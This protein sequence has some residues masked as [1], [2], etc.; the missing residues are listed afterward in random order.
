M[1]LLVDEDVAGSH[2]SDIP[3]VSLEIPLGCDESVEE[4]PEVCLFEIFLFRSPP[5]DFIPKV[6]GK[7]RVC[8]ESSSSGAAHFL[9]RGEAGMLGEQQKLGIEFGLRSDNRILPLIIGFGLHR[10]SRKDLV[11]LLIFYHFG[12]GK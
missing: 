2:V 1:L 4:V 5:G 10:H 3:P 12:I 11:T 8:I 9:I 6:D 7:M